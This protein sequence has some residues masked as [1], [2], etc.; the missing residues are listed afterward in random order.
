MFNNNLKIYKKFFK[1]INYKKLQS[2]ILQHEKKL[3]KVLVKTKIKLPKGAALNFMG[4]GAGYKELNKILKCIY[5]FNLFYKFFK[6]KFILNNCGAVTLYPSGKN[7]Q[8]STKWHRDT[9][10]YNPKAKSEMLLLVIPVTFCSIENGTTKYKIKKK[11]YTY[12]QPELNPGDLL[13]A[14]ARTLHKG[15]VNTSNKPRTIITICITPPHI[16]PIINFSS[17]IKDPKKMKDYQLQLMG[18]YSRVPE[19]LFDFFKPESERFFLKNQMM[20]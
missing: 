1:K 6:S 14:D 16:K 2:E 11:K 5:D 15:G 7:Y 18:Y 4:V 20:L 12:V 13:V 17:F 19:T 9:R 3:D 8:R 10:Y